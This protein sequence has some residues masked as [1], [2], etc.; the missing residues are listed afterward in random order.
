[1]KDLKKHDKNNTGLTSE[2]L[3]EPKQ[4]DLLSDKKEEKIDIF[5][6]FKQSKGM[7]V[8][9]TRKKVVFQEEDDNEQAVDLL[10][11]PVKVEFLE[12]IKGTIN[13]ENDE[14]K[15]DIKGE[16][17]LTVNSDAVRHVRLPVS[18]PKLK[19]NTCF[20]N[21]K[22]FAAGHLESEVID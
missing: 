5:S 16:I 4:H 19:F 15:W 3:V 8:E 6:E 11:E 2:S 18:T 13:L 20:V 1:M 14:Y 7:S 21:K 9:E 22:E 12:R 17:Y 10:K